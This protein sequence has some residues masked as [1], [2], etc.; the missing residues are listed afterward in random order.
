MLLSVIPMTVSAADASVDAPLTL[1]YIGTNCTTDAADGNAK[2]LLDGKTNTKWCTKHALPLTITFRTDGKTVVKSMQLYSANDTS[3]ANWA[4]RNW[5]AWSLYGWDAS[6]GWVEIQSWSDEKPQTTYGECSTYA[7]TNDTAYDKYQLEISANWGGDAK[8]FTAQMA[9]MKLI[10]NAEN[11]T[12]YTVTYNSNGGSTVSSATG[13]T[14][15]PTLPVPTKSEFDFIGWY[16]DEAL[17]KEAKAGDA[18]SQDTTLYARWGNKTSALALTYVDSNS[19]NF[20]SDTGNAK[21]LLD[22]KIDT[23]WCT[24]HSLPL[25]LEFSTATNTVVKSMELYA[26]NDTYVSSLQGRNWKSWILYGLDASGAWVEIQSWSNQTPTITYG[27][28]STFSISN[29]I[30]YNK[31]QLV[32]SANKGGTETTNTVQMAEMKLYGYNQSYAIT[33]ELNGGTNGDNPVSYTYGTGVASFANATRDGYLFDGWYDAAE[34]G[35]KI[36][37]VSSTATGDKTLYAHWSRDY[38]TNANYYKAYDVVVSKDG[39]SFKFLL[40][41]T[42]HGGDKAFVRCNM[43]FRTGNS[44]TDPLSAF[45]NGKGYYYESA[46]TLN[47]ENGQ[48]T[49]DIDR[50][51]N[52]VTITINSNEIDV[53]DFLTAE[54]PY[55]WLYVRPCWWKD[56]L[57]GNTTQGTAYYN[58]IVYL[59]K[60]SSN[61]NFQNGI[62]EYA[63]TVTI[64]SGITN[65]TVS[66]TKATKFEGE[67]VVLNVTP[68]TGYL[69]DTVPYTP[70]G[71]TATAITETDGVYSFT[72]PN[73]DVTVNATFVSNTYVVKVVKSDSTTNYYT[74]LSEAVNNS[75]S[76]DTIVMLSSSVGNITIPSDKVLTL[77]LNGFVLKG[78][79][80]SSVITNNGTLTIKDSKPTAVHKYVVGSDGLWTWN[81]SADGTAIALENLTA[82]ATASNVIAVKGGAITGGVATDGGGV[83][84]TGTL[85][86][87][88]GNIV[89]CKA[90]SHGGGVA[91]IPNTNATFAMTG[92]AIIGCIGHNGG[93]VSNDDG[94][95]FTMSD[96]ALISNCMATYV[97]GGVCSTGTFNMNGGTIAD[98]EVKSDSNYGGGVCNGDNGTFTMAGGTITRCKTSANNGGGVVSSGIFT[99]T[100]GTISDCT[101]VGDGGGVRIDDKGSFTMTGGTIKNCTSNGNGGGIH[102]A[103]TIPTVTIGGSAVITG[104]KK[105][106]AANNIYLPS[107]KT[108]SVNAPTSM[109]VGV[110]TATAP[111]AGNPVAVTSAKDADYSNYFTSDNVS[112]AVICDGTAGDRQV[113][114]SVDYK[115]K[116]VKSDG[117][118]N[119]YTSLSDAISN[120]ESGDTVVMLVSYNGNITIPQGKDI[121]LDLNGFTLTTDNAKVQLPTTVL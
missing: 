23:K 95:S 100:G 1:T 91:N 102:I 119:Y 62:E 116:T 106:S 9:E 22:G 39:I 98:C 84:N 45:P 15:L 16:T 32:I 5:K 56:A 70:A 50:T 49:L 67:K 57:D 31:Y 78:D 30:S 17:T 8:G 37:T 74:S 63:G 94:R 47:M 96:T 81:D 4:G 60:Y 79:G 41:Q 24:T 115:A 92:G 82:Y 40:D 108:V 68:D 61:T 14:T 10:G 117:T 19:I 20:D 64:D 83:Y 87:S 105:G 34:D 7:I 120:A 113:K 3:D 104:N 69:V 46:G 71:G 35:N 107:G 110:T 12:T 114:L 111:T 48:G 103:G 66:V 55:L 59:G 109:N 118:T 121:T 43:Q 11:Q 53:S 89:G 97:G 42:G 72:M 112:Y 76:G 13:R 38:G 36:T 80:T 33:Y 58:D 2:M 27:Q 85:T 75:A 52:I 51:E 101:A 90:S 65:G 99:I 54:K 25:T 21:M 73:S 26:A 77:D 86:M 29:N 93:G 18:I 44:S 28:C 6:N 88:S